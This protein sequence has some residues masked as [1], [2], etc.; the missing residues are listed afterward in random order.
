LVYKDMSLNPGINQDKAKALARFLWWAV[1]SGQQYAP[2]LI[3]V[4]LPQNV[5]AADEQVLMGL[6]Y[7]GQQLLS[8]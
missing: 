6:N 1:H 3:Y 4:P 7:Q 5:V 8:Q 2:D